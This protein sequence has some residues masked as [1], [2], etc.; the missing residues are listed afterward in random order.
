M[1]QLLIVAG[2]F[3]LYIGIVVVSCSY[4][5]N[6]ETNIHKCVFLFGFENTKKMAFNLFDFW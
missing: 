1:L 4:S 6:V 3:L 5:C 2:R